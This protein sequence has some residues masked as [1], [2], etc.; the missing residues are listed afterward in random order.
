[1]IIRIKYSDRSEKR[2]N[3][4]LVHNNIVIQKAHASLSR[5]FFYS[6]SETFLVVYKKRDYLKNKTFGK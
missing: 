1:M 5:V 4:E 2:F 6:L 3:V